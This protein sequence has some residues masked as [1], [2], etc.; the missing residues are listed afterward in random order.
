MNYQ[1]EIRKSRHPRWLILTLTTIV[2]L[3]LACNLMLPISE[4]PEPIISTAALAAMPAATSTATSVPQDADTGETPQVGADH[5]NGGSP[6]GFHPAGVF[7]PGYPDNGFVDA[8]NIG[9]KWAREGVYALWFVVQ[10][11]LGDPTY[12]FT[13]YDRQYGNIPTDV[14]ILANIAPQGRIDEG[15]CLPGSWM[16]VDDAQ[17]TAFVTATVERYDGDGV[18][19]MPGLANPIKYWQVG[20]EP[21][22]QIQ[23]DFAGLQRIT[24]QAIKQACPDCMVMIGGAT[25]FPDNYVANFDANFAPILAELGGQYVDVF[26]FHWYGTATGEYRLR[27]A[28]TSQDV[29]DHIRT[30]LTANGF[31][32][33]LPIWITEMG[34]YSGDPADLPFAALPLQTERQQASDYFKRFIYPLSRGVDKV[35]PAFGLM[36]GFKHDDSYFD[37][38]GLIYDG[39]DTGDLGLGV[40]KLG[41][42]TY[43]KMTEMLEGADWSTLTTLHDGTD[44]DHLYL[45][46]V[47]KACTELSRSDG[48]PIHI[49]WWDYFDKPVYTPGDTKPITLTDLT[50]TTITVTTVVPAADTGQDVTDYATAFTVATYPV[51]DGSATILLGEDPVLVEQGE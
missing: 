17:Y 33:G 38:T 20:N 4:T 15:R 29:Y 39:E 35:F 8:A 48:P 37:H 6:F 49:A 7:K 40:K 27:D 9:V 51:S 19:D 16:P 32:P 45:F 3:G 18:D 11:E 26:D 23:S 36:E 21:N 43:K 2:L 30:T 5:P 25:S 12:N 24:Y 10:P 47:E 44:S 34:A 13:L 42:Y 14:S 46:R 31:S 41:Y 28:A 1:E 50:G 22:E